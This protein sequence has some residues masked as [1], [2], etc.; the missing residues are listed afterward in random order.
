[1]ARGGKMIDKNIL[2]T[3]KTIEHLSAL[4]RDQSVPCW[5]LAF[6]ITNAYKT[7]NAAS[8]STLFD[9]CSYGGQGGNPT[10]Y[11]AGKLTALQLDSD[12]SAHHLNN[13]YHNA[14]HLKQVLINT[15]VISQLSDRKGIQPPP[16]DL[17]IAAMI[18]DVNH[19]G[20]TNTVN[21]KH[22][23]FRLEDKSMAYARPLFKAAWVDD[24]TIRDI[25]TMLRWTDLAG[26]AEDMV[27]AY[28]EGLRPDVAEKAK[29][30]GDADLLPAIGLTGPQ[31]CKENEKLGLEWDKPLSTRNFR[32]FVKGV[33]GNG[34]QSQGAKYFNPNIERVVAYMDSLSHKKHAVGIAPSP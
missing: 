7:I 17:L 13:D 24:Q 6:E 26:R 5:A 29:M 3:K 9:L 30:L 23:P 12:L 20:S 31:A 14:D 2:T 1:M 21:G 10:L 8:F 4:C 32:S 33:A 19:D 27:K 28:P 25:Q 22:I 34:F 11:E 16:L 15:F 18:H